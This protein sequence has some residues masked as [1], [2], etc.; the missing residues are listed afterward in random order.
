MCLIM[1]LLERSNHLFS[2]KNA[3]A[4]LKWFSDIH[5]RQRKLSFLWEFFFFIFSCRWQFFEI[6]FFSASSRLRW[7]IN[8]III[9]IFHFINCGVIRRLLF[10]R[11]E[12]FYGIFSAKKK[13]S[14]LM[15]WSYCV[16]HSM[17]GLNLAQAY[18]CKMCDW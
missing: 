2:D 10:T 14:A 7:L 9:S 5:R 16:C 12:N 3:C 15:T 18:V 17:I 6:L 4:E 8:F 13:A 11:I 1:C